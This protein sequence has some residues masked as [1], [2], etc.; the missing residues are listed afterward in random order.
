MSKKDDAIL[1]VLR[2]NARKS[3]KELAQML[4]MPISTV[5]DR[6]KKLEE[7]GVIEGYRAVLNPKKL[8]KGM[9][10]IVSIT[11]SYYSRTGEKVSQRKLA[12]KLAA[13]QCVEEVH[14]VAGGND[15]IMKVRVAN[16]DELNRFVIDDL[17][18]IDGVDKTQTAIILDSVKDTY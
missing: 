8:G 16:V 4:G 2:T 3:T 13:I 6:I 1:E 7:S 12:E 17:R 15:I 11:V 5:Y 9:G 18:N 10:A 14:I